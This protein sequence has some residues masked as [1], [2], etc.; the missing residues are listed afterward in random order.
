VSR[1]LVRRLLR[2]FGVPVRVVLWN[3]EVVPSACGPPVATLY[4]RDRWIVWQLL[5]GAD[6]AFGEAYAE[7]RIEVEGDLV[8]LLEPMFHVYLMPQRGEPVVSW[9]AR[10][11]GKANSVAR[12]RGNVRHHYDLSNDFYRLW[13]DE[14]MV[15]TC[16]Y[17]PS[18]AL[19]LE[20]A[21]IAKMEHVCRKLQ[22]EAGQTVF[23]AGCGWGALARYMARQYG[24]TVTACNLS[25][26]QIEYARGQA[27]A[28]GL[29]GQVRFV[30]DDY[31][32][33]TGT[34]DRF[35]SVGMLEHVGLKHYRTLGGVIHRCLKPTGR[36]LVHSIGRNSPRAMSPWLTKH[37]FPG[38]YI[39]SL[40]EIMNVFEP[41]QFSI[42][43]VENLRLHYARTLAHWLGRFES[44]VDRV[45]ARFGEQFVRMW[46]LYLAISQASFS[47][48]NHQLFQVVFAPWTNN[49]VPWSRA[50]LYQS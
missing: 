28:E 41:W 45:R 30:E 13:L 23:E 17:F 27:Q 33:I 9:L 38:A 39:P 5:A 47:A 10:C 26:E 32:N 16:A 35:V 25:H 50:H 48:G 21:Q 24:V 40:G 46:R 44:V 36:G 8:A 3:G 43:D 12:S 6:P 37:I 31:R 29:Q 18:P 20:E 1:W 7:G 49:D 19:T 22:L 34:F 42:L 2:Q 14:Q 11:L 15:Y 4:F